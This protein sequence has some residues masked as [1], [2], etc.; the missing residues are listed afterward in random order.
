MESVRCFVLHI[1][2][3]L[4]VAASANVNYVS[5]G[6]PP[7]VIVAKDGSGQYMTVT[8]GI[9]SYPANYKGRYVIYVKAGI[10][11]EYVTVDEK[12]PNIILY[13][14]GPTNTIITGSKNSK[15]GLQMPDTATFS[16]YPSFI[17]LLS[18]ML[19]EKR[20]KNINR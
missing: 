20:E 7:N 3:F 10:Y 1:S 17:P 16:N 19:I 11:N 8:A 6:M 9:N 15:Q 12:K 14:D 5:G 13:G 18:L 2:L 4:L